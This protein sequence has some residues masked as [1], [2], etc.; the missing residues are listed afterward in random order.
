MDAT[1]PLMPAAYDLVWSGLAV[2]VLGLAVWAIVS[3]CRSAGWLSSTS[4][5]MWVIVILAVPVLGP[6]S[7]LAA[8]RR[9]GLSRT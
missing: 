8:G 4:V 6:V 2:V 3:L 1:N 9:A 7:W 5:L